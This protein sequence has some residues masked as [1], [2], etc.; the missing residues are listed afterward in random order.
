MRNPPAAFKHDNPV[1]SS[2]GK[3]GDGSLLRKGFAS[4]GVVDPEELD[5]NSFINIA[6]RQNLEAQSD[7]AW[8]QAQKTKAEAV[9]QE[10]CNRI[11]E[12]APEAKC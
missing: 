7:L 3:S 4:G 9:S 10:E 2:Y 6:K 5:P 1:Y 8:T 12:I 11:K